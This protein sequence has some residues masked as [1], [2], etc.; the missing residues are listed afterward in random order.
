M[1]V[2]RVE[3]MISCLSYKNLTSSLSAETEFIDFFG[4]SHLG[5]KCIDSEAFE[6]DKD[7]SFGSGGFPCVELLI[8]PLSFALGNL[9]VSPGTETESGL[10]R[11]IYI[12]A[13]EYLQVGQNCLILGSISNL[14]HISNGISTKKDQFSSSIICFKNP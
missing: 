14:Q 12:S 7:S 11:D 3:M 1:L 6:H 4:P 2:K 10:A 13:N 5:S 9:L 8:Y